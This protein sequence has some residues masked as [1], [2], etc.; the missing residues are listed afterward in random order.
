MRSISWQQVEDD[1]SKL[2]EA[3]WGGNALPEEVSGV[4]CD[5][6]LKL[7]REHWII[8]EISKNDSLTKVREDLAK[9]GVIKPSLI[10]KGIYTECYFVTSGEH[11]SIQESGE[12]MNVEVHTLKSFA[13]KFLG[14]ELYITER[15]RYPFG[16]ALNPDSGDKDKS[17]YIPICYV[18]EDNNKYTIADICNKLIS[19]KK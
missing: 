6:V 12:G 19:G 16:S 4:K 14:L 15:L 17:F 3:I 11:P 1:I 5:A 10:S 13:N 2:A 7:K 9:F 8:I 18:D